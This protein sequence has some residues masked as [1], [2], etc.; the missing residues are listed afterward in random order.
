MVRCSGE[1]I[2]KTRVSEGQHL[3]PTR[4]SR[5][6]CDE[7]GTAFRDSE[8]F[9]GVD[10]RATCLG[11]VESIGRD[12]RMS[13][14]LDGDREVSLDPRAHPHLDHGY[15]VTSHSSQGQTSDR[16]LIH[17]DTELGAR[18]LLNNR[19][20]YVSVS[21]GAHDAQIFTND[22]EKLPAALGHDVSH[23][24]AYVP[25]MKQEQVVTPQREIAPKQEN[26]D[27]GLG[28]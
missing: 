23:K 10:E 15:A 18:D 16:V 5:K 7:Q 8:L 14:K 13:L 20:A 1:M 2:C 26:F 3:A 19:M 27:I 6:N 24:S 11:V 4:S 12:G 17:V 28:L 21:R 25:E 22:R 9:F